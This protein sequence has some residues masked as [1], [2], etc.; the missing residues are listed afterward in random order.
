MRK[1]TTAL[2]PRARGLCPRA[3]NPKRRTRQGVTRRVKPLP[4]EVRLPKI[5]VLE[6]LVRAPLEHEPPG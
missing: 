3:F 6:Q 1:R 5:L 2:N 4:P